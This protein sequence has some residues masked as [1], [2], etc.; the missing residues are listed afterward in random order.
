MKKGGWSLT[1]S[2]QATSNGTSC[3]FWIAHRH[4]RAN[5]RDQSRISQ[6]G[7]WRAARIRIDC[8]LGALPITL[9]GNQNRGKREEGREKKEEE[10]KELRTRGYQID[11]AVGWSTAI[12]SGVHSVVGDLN[13]RIIVIGNLSPVA[14]L[15]DNGHSKPTKR[16]FPTIRAT[17]NVLNC[18]SCF[19][20]LKF[21]PLSYICV[22]E[23]SLKHPPV[24]LP[25]LA[26]GEKGQGLSP[27]HAIQTVRVNGL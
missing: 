21:M 27:T 10:E 25:S 8:Y 23:R 17:Q 11:E 16:G 22:A 5:R 20:H 1:C 18:S 4:C 9:Q 2:F 26:E 15:E 13:V 14:H 19:G 7:R 12:A 3:S 24:H 6:S